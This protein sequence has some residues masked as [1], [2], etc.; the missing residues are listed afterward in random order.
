MKF[1]FNSKYAPLTNRIAF[2][3]TPI[4]NVIQAHE[5]WVKGLLEPIPYNIKVCGSN[6]ESL[7]EVSLPYMG[8]CAIV[9]V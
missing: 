3:N 1:L 2:L 5:S 7:L 4:D 6:F 9:R 8:S